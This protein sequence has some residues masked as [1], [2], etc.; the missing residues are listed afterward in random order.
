MKAWSR[1]GLRGRLALSIGALFLV[2][3]GVVFV[4]VR[5]EMAN[6]SRV[7]D[8]EESHDSSAN[9]GDGEQVVR[10]SISPISD[11][12]EEM[13]ETFL[14]VGAAALVVA[15]AGAYLIA[16]R[17][18]SPLRRMAASAGAAS[19]PMPRMSCARR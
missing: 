7:I 3:F 1:I 19:S 8:R 17:T 9:G 12:Q 5:A 18:A 6:E 14:I 16:S 2:A 15:L 13:E 11:A 4:A 10:P